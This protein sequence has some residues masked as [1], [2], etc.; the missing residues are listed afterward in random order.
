MI[1]FHLKKSLDKTGVKIFGI[2]NNCVIKNVCVCL[3]AYKYTCK[4]RAEEVFG[5]VE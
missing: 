5:V 1:N 4:F 3:H 2:N